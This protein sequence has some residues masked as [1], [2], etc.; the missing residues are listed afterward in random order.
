[1]RD[2]RNGD[3]LVLIAA[4]AFGAFV[5][6]VLS[7]FILVRGPCH[8][9]DMSCWQEWTNAWKSWGVLAS[10][11]AGVLILVM[12][13]RQSMLSNQRQLRAYI[14]AKNGTVEGIET[15]NIV[16]TLT[17]KNYGA[18]PANCI[19]I[20][21]DISVSPCDGVMPDVFTREPIKLNDTF[22]NEKFYVSFPY[23]K[24]AENDIDLLRSNEHWLLIYGV[25]LYKDA[26]G[27]GRQTWFKKFVA[28]ENG[29]LK[30]GTLVSSALPNNST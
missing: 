25:V 17:F 12:T 1:V 3:L 9:G 5:F 15:S 6:M 16:F 11:V 29:T 18:T 24:L 4:A 19:R 2:W 30:N 23:E 22:P 21:A 14:D 8:A 20:Y 7:D 28:C 27:E 13:L 10:S 26:F